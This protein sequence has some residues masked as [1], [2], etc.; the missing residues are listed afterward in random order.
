MI[1]ESALGYIIVVQ[2]GIVIISIL[3]REGQSPRRFMA[4]TGGLSGLG[5]Y[6]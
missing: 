5:N 1:W 4:D 2:L 6:V 3:Y